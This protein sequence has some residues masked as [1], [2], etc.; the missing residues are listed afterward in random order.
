MIRDGL[1]RTDAER[2]LAAQ[3]PIERKVQLAD[4]VIRT[5]GTFAETDAQVAALVARLTAR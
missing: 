3:W 2:R 5:D 4:H 1:S